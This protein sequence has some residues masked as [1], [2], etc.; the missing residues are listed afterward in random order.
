[1]S[2]EYFGSMAWPAQENQR[3][4]VIPPAN[5]LRK[6]ALGPDFSSQEVVEML[7]MPA[8]SLQV[9]LCSSQIIYRLY[10]TR[11]KLRPRDQSSI[12]N[13]ILQRF[14]RGSHL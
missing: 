14:A 4:H 8:S 2:G 3:L 13:I 10:D 11:S 12:D 1:M 6:S 7:A 5:T 9:L